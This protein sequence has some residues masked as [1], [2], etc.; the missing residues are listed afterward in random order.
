MKLKEIIIKEPI[1]RQVGS[2]STWISESGYR[3]LVEEE[4]N[5]L[6]RIMDGE[7]QIWT[8]WF[9]LLL[10]SYY[11][12]EPYN[13]E[14]LVDL[15]MEDFKKSGIVKKD[16]D[17]LG[18]A[19]ENNSLNFV[20]GEKNSNI[21]KRLFSIDLN[22]PVYG[23]MDL[24]LLFGDLENFYDLL[25]EK[26][27]VEH[28]SK[29]EFKSNGVYGNNYND[30]VNR[31]KMIYIKFYEATDFLTNL[32]YYNQFEGYLNDDLVKNETLSEY[33]E[34]YRKNKDYIALTKDGMI[35]IPYGPCLEFRNKGLIIKG[36]LVTS[37]E[38]E[39]FINFIGEINKENIK[40]IKVMESQFIEGIGV[41]KVDNPVFIYLSGAIGFKRIDL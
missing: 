21:I 40:G 32:T 4:S 3:F 2:L 31:V 8:S 22:F 28:K 39:D 19:I 5:S 18:Y 27:G 7:N 9:E 33:K 37:S 12:F 35:G 15:L 26:L 10:V 13:R 23:R 20:L 11:Y 17:L 25:V 30:H 34:Y 6:V 36:N 38:R 1:K 16:G 24:R 29:V 41:I 14:E